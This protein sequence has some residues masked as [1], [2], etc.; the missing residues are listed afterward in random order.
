LDIN[1]LLLVMH[2]EPT[3][4]RSSF[5]NHEDGNRVSLGKEDVEEIQ[6]EEGHL[7][8]V[9]ENQMKVAELC[10]ASELEAL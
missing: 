10:S 4:K 2:L 5:I 9:L 1:D 3:N 7:S 6:D 8:D